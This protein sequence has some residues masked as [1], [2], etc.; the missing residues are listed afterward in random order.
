MPSAYWLDQ[1]PG[2]PVNQLGKSGV[3]YATTVPYATSLAGS[4]AATAKEETRKDS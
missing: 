1:L 4:A 3:L 2:F